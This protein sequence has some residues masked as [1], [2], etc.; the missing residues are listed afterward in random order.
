MI[1]GIDISSIPYGTGVSNYTSNLVRHLLK[2]DKTNQYKL[3]FY[4][5][6]Q[7]LPL[8]IK[9][10]SKL[11]NVKLYYYHLPPTFFEIA[12]NKLQFLPLELFIG[13]CDI[14]HSWDWIHPPTIKAKIV[15]TV[16]DL[17]PFLFPKYQHT[18]TIKVFTKK[19]SLAQTAKN[20]FI[21]VSQNTKKDFT[22]R[23][24]NIISGKTT[25]IYEAADDKYR[26]F[27]RLPK[28]KQQERITRLRQ[29]YG[30]D[31]FVLTQGTREPR[32]NLVKLI[33]AFC[34]FKKNHPRNKTV[35]AISGKYGW[36]K[37]VSSPHPDIKILGYIPEKDMV[38]L[39]ASATALAFPSLYEGFGLPL[40]KSMAVGVP[41]LTSNLPPMTEIVDDAALL[42][43]PKSVNSIYKGLTT[44]LTNKSTRQKL[45]AKSLI[46]S[47]KF[48]WDKTAQQT[49]KFYESVLIK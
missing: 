29:Q 46:Q 9:A 28:A 47:A 5:L 25:V 4:S 36:G 1:I 40:L 2:I 13:K 24:P 37:D 17:V 48:S 45:V 14:F 35:L 42:I 8:E 16:H 6:R 3:L 19:F 7:D 26:Q 27:S 39:H 15:T 18:K 43:D 11:S 10:L 41:V 44:I 34:L 30:L 38:A 20:F 33:K 31:N 49:L 12:W 23:Y 21:C 22:N 32:K